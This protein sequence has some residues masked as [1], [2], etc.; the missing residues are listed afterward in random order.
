MASLMSDEVIVFVLEK[1][2][3]KGKHQGLI[4][5]TSRLVGKV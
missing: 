5:E 2:L 3:K 4:K 1:N